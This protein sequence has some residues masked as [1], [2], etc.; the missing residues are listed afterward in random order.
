MKIRYFIITAFLWACAAC[1]KD[2][3]VMPVTFD[4]AVAKNNGT[5]TTVFSANDTTRFNFSGNPDMIIYFRGEQV[6][7]YDF[8][9]RVSREGSPNY[10]SKLFAQTER[11]PILCLC[12]FRPISKAARPSK[13]T[14]SWF[15]ITRLPMPI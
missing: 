7:N 11:S 8:K 2:I 9:N 15:A 4:V 5:K 12:S 6:K 13:L 10:S 1:N 14:A 3:A